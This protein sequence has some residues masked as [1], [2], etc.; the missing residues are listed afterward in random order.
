MISDLHGHMG[1]Y[2]FL[3][4]QMKRHVLHR[5]CAHLKV[6]ALSLVCRVWMKLMQVA[7]KIY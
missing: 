6:P 1:P 7:K 4:L 2:D 5:A 3:K